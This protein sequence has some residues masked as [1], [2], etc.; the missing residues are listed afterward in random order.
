MNYYNNNFEILKQNPSDKGLFAEG[1]KQAL[2]IPTK[3]L[4]VI[5]SATSTALYDILNILNHSDPLLPIII[6]SSAVQGKKMPN[7]RLFVPL[8]LP[9][10]TKNAMYS[11][12]TVMVH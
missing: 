3:R 1:Y 9:I 8:T 7:D 2:P 10:T 4:C 6:Y 12:L 5:T 11:L